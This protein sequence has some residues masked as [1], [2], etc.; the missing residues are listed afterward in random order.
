MLVVAFLVYMLAGLTNRRHRSVSRS[1]IAP[2]SFS[3]GRI[4][5]ANV[6]SRCVGLVVSEVSL[7]I[8]IHLVTISLRRWFQSCSIVHLPRYK[9]TSG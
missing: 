4:E 2:A 7:T 1:K 9:L 6:K 5:Q 3:F 8:V